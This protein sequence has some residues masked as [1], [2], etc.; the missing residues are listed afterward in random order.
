MQA[1]DWDTDSN[2]DDDDQ[3]IGK[4]LHTLKPM[5]DDTCNRNVNDFEYTSTGDSIKV[6]YQVHQKESKLIAV[7]IKK[8]L[9]YPENE[10]DSN[11]NEKKLNN[12]LKKIRMRQK[13]TV[14]ELHKKTPDITLQSFFDRR[15]QLSKSSGVC[16]QM[17]KTYGALTSAMA[18]K[19]ISVDNRLGIQD[20]GL[21]DDV[22]KQ[23][24]AGAKHFTEV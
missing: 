15:D 2:E 12:Y 10:I 24:K 14:E 3:V 1:I 13:K 5:V 20:V 11:E 23:I 7:R 21:T 16:P 6:F 18:D 8:E 19:I 9:E 4:D 17:I 22:T